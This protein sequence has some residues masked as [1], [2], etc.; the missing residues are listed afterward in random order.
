M[1]MK[2]RGI[3]PPIAT[4]L[5][6]DERVDEVGLRRLVRYLLDA[7]VHGLF[8]NGSMG[9][10]ALLTDDEQ[11]RAIEIVIDEVGR[12]V[13]VLAGAS[14]TG[15]K[16]V[17]EKAR[18][19]ERLNPDFLV[20][21]PPYYYRL[22]QHSAINFFHQVAQNVSKPILIY[23]NPMAMRFQLDL[24][25]IIQLSREP[26]ITGIKT[27]SQDLDFWAKLIACFRH[28]E[29]FSVLLGTELLI[30]FGL[31]MGADGIVGGLYNIAPQI[32]V[33]I[34]SAVQA[35]NYV[36]AFTLA[37]KLAGLSKIFEHGEIWGGF[38]A[39]LQMLGICDKATASPYSSLEPAELAKVDSILK[40]YLP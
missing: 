36:N 10:F 40:E 31:M 27:N 24:E 26:M 12:K 21:L 30:A 33:A 35:G 34:Y 38:E 3:I 7:G 18:Q 20:I 28:S 4:P 39:A 8:V 22:T 15:T 13:P 29:D 14:D 6:S 16:R 32:A 1:I 23:D 25:S 5:L 9:G 17:I 37:D 11:L 2:L 19:I